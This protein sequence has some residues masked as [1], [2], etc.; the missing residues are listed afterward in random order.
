MRVTHGEEL[1]LA[2]RIM[3]SKGSYRISIDMLRL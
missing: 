2:R 1:H 3:E